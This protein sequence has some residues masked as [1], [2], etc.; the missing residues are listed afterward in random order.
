MEADRA[1]LLQGIKD[2]K[3]VYCKH[4]EGPVKPN[5]TFFGEALPQEFCEEMGKVNNADLLIVIGTALAVA[6]FNGMVDMI[7]DSVRKVLINM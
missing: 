3:V 6:P 7:P 1:E 5:I 4:C 2:S